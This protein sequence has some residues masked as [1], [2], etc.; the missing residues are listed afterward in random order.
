MYII[1]QLVYGQNIAVKG[2]EHLLDDCD[3]YEIFDQLELI[4]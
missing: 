3:E 4:K 1:H 2:N